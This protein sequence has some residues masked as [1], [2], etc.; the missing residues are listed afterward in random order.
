MRKFLFTA[1]S[2]ED[3]ER[4][5]ELAADS[6]DFFVTVGVHPCRAAEVTGEATES[7][8]ERVSKYFEDVRNLLRDA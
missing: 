5:L 7:D 3:A 1:G 6:P 2:K 8:P 4:A